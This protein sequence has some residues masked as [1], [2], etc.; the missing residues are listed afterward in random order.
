VFNYRLLPTLY[1]RSHGRLR[2]RQ[3]DDATLPR[4][5]A[6]TSSKAHTDLLGLGLTDVVCP[7]DDEITADGICAFGGQ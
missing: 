3:I 1:A 7:D 5:R 2:E 6:A 4:K